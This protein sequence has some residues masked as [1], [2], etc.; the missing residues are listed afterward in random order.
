MVILHAR[1][2]IKPEGRERW[3]A[4]LDAVTPPSRAE[5]AVS[6]ILYEAIETPDTFIFVEE[7][8]QASMVCT[9]ISTRR[10]SPSSSPRSERCSPSRPRGLSPRC[11]RH[12]RSTKRLRLP[13]SRDKTVR[14]VRGGDGPGRWH[15]GRHGAGLSSVMK[16]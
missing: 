14:R 4:L 9:P 12:K 16:G 6:Y 11:P 1:V 10:T 2:A 8:G 15:H 3:L 5:D 13:A 7:N